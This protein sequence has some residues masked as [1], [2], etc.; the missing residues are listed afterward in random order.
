MTTENSRTYYAKR[1]II[2]GAVNQI[3]AIGAPF[4]VRTMLIYSLGAEFLGLN[5][6]FASILQ[7]FNMADMGFSSAITFSLYKPLARKDTQRICALMGFY[8]K[9]YKLIG[10]GLIIVGLGLMPF[11]PYL[12]KGSSPEGIN[13]YILYLIYLANTSISYLFFAY[14]NALLSASQ[15]QDILSNI[16]TLV[17]IL[18]A[19]TQLLM[20]ILFSNYYLYVVCLPIFSLILNILVAIITNKMYPDYICTRDLP[21]EDIIAII[22]QVKGLLIG[23]VGVISRNSFDTIIIS[24][25]FGLIDAAIYSNYYYI[26]SAVLCIVTIFTDSIRGSVGNSIAIESKDK[27][28]DDFLRFNY[29]TAWI[30]SWCMICLL[31]LYQPFMY[32][33][34]KGELV[35]SNY[36]MI[37]FCIYFYISQMGQMR[38]VYSSAAGIWWELRYLQIGEAVSNLILNIGLG[39][40]LGMEGVLYA[41]IISVTLFSFIGIGKMLMQIYFHRSSAEYFY[42]MLLYTLVTMFVS[43]VTYFACSFVN[44]TGYAVILI[45]LLVC[46]ILPNIIFIVLSLCRKRYREYLKRLKEILW[47]KGRYN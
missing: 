9:V 37:L 36:T 1:N 14:K 13:I 4:V 5:S 47:I 15:R 11:L 21:K 2:W 6:V 31:C 20:L 27:N 23:K 41:T 22:T 29:Y 7:V 43:I 16:N 3:V 18:R 28:Y 45:R 38:A 10:L 25:F 34:T 17:I 30:G 35:A 8:R 39:Y 44:G 42:E 32:L 19:V 33:W 26:L 40:F 46:G 24:A 12:V